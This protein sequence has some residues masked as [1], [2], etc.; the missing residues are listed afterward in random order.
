MYTNKNTQFTKKLT[1]AIAANK[2]LKKDCGSNN[3]DQVCLSWIVSL[4]II[5][6]YYIGSITFHYSLLPLVSTHCKMGKAES[7]CFDIQYNLMVSKLQ[8]SSS[9]GHLTSNDHARSQML[10]DYSFSDTLK[11]NHMGDGHPVFHLKTTYISTTS[12]WVNTKI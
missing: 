7:T 12:Y 6:A 1:M 3:K 5:N 2:A 4:I 11:K 9:S 10:E 8:M